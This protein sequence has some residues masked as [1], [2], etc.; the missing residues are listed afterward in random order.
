ML[1][2]DVNGK[3]VNVRDV[4][5]GPPAILLH[6]AS[7]HSGQWKWLRERLSDGFRV[8]A[9]DLHGYGGSDPLPDDG[10]PFSG[11]MPLL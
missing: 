5:Q 8:L 10:R 9:P 6:S 4:G 1:S 3:N 11:T 2:L 7:S